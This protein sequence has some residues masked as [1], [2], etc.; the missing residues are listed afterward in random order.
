LLE[1][2]EAEI[3][4]AESIARA[5]LD[6]YVA[7]GGQYRIGQEHQWAYSEIVEF[8]NFRM[9][10]AAASLLL[11]DQGYVGDALGLC[12]SLLENYL[13]LK[14]IC[15]GTK[16][17][18]L[19]D[20][21]S[22]TDGQFKAKLR[23]LQTANEAARGRGDEAWLDIRS[24]PRP[25]KRHAMLIFEGLRSQDEPDFLVPLHYFQFREF[26]P[27]TMRLNAERY[28][29]YYESPP[30]V[31]K[32]QAKYRDGEIFRYRH[33]LSYDALLECLAL[34]GLATDAQQA[35]ID[36]HYTFLGKFIHPT[37]EAARELHD[38][39]NVHDG[40]P[41]I[42]MQV[43]YSRASVLLANIYVIH[44][45]A[46]ILDEIAYLFEN[47]PKRYISKPGTEAIRQT[48]REVRSRFDYFWLIYNEA[49]LYDRWLFAIHHMSDDELKSCGG[50]AGVSSDAVSFHQGIY[51]HFKNA[52]NGWSN[53]R[54]GTYISPLARH[55]VR[56]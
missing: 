53:R 38:H 5:L 7:F 50:A 42:G 10:T 4:D 39:S 33:Y 28:F 31:A 27:E 34:N 2:I 18:R 36:A 17:F 44:L 3:Q 22:L 19:Q 30:E 37:H 20:F 12:R 23:E 41:R 51:S 21:G 8:V 14:L 52:L 9:E 40:R 32:A 26:R 16:A 56:R 6:A 25:P 45:V 47:A 13:L 15:R 46:D 24:Y 1:P 49:P 29:V 54:C 43:S 48:A 55:P 35:R 11:A